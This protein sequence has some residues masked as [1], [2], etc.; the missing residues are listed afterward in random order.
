M[1]PRAVVGHGAMLATSLGQSWQELPRKDCAWPLV[2]AIG[3]MAVARPLN[4]ALVA[5]A[6]GSS[7]LPFLHSGR[8]ALTR[9][10]E[11]GE[12]EIGEPYHDG[13]PVWDGE[14]AFARAR[15]VLLRQQD[16]H[17]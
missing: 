13:D 2:S 10:R 12:E 5:H 16:K 9:L 8:I 14:R 7:F 17:N 15:P 1:V 11:H 4:P 6:G 3:L